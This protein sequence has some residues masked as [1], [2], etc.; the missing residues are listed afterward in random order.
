MSE[1]NRVEYTVEVDEESP[2]SV[3]VHHAKGGTSIIV[4][5]GADTVRISFKRAL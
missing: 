3:T 2:S 1:Q 5:P 4:D